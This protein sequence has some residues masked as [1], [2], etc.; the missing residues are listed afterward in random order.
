MRDVKRVSTGGG[1]HGPVPFGAT[2]AGKYPPLSCSGA[3]GARAPA[4]EGY[5]AGRCSRSPA[6]SHSEAVAMIAITA[7]MATVLHLSAVSS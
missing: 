1:S 4:G 5:T 3:T 7:P 6:L 2:A